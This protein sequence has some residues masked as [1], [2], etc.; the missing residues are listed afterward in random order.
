LEQNYRSTGA[1]I[2]A[3]TEL[4]SRNRARKGKTLWTDNPQGD[5]LELFSAPDDRLEAAWVARR[6]GQLGPAI[7][8]EEIAVLYRTNAQSRQMEETF[9]RESIPH[10]VVGS[11]RFYERK[12]VKD[13]LA[14]LKLAANPADDVAFRRVVNTP[15]RGIGQTTLTL[16]GEIARATGRPLMEAAAHAL[17]QGLLSTRPAKNLRAFL[18]YMADLARFGD[19]Q[20]VV[21]L[22]E[23]IIDDVG[24]EDYLE[25]L[26]VG[27]GADRMENVRALVSAAAEHAEESDQATLQTFLDRSALVSDADEV[28]G[29]PGVTL[30]TIHCAKGL[31]FS[32]VFLVG[33]E[34]NL[35]PHAMSSGSD[36]DLEEERRLCYVAMTRA[37]QRLMLTHAHYRRYQGALIPNPPSRFIDEIPEELVVAAASPEDPGFFDRQTPSTGGGRPSGGSSA[38][39]AGSR[40]RRASPARSPKAS[41]PPPD[42][43]YAV[44]AFVHHPTFGSGQIHQ[45][46]GSGKHLKLTI[47]FSDHGTKKIL[48]AYTKLR[49][50]VG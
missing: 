29:R 25:K 3:A 7:A 28:G 2:Q 33:L 38:A 40:R 27:Q 21:D 17:E 22:I 36:E 11:V 34:E 16:V 15:P 47:H 30:M 9:R 10:Q 6:I 44:G 19:D 37:R 20:P 45:R 46:E 4:I 31:E 12:E 14:Y 42:D 32:A 1:I 13:L 8:L 49:V 18:D 24:L 35:F 5:R 23:R 43:G 48:P 39:R 26:Y 41:G 50:Q